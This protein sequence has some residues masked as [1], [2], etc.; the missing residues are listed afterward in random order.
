MT[1]SVYLGLTMTGGLSSK[2]KLASGSLTTELNGHDSMT[3][4][5]DLDSLRGIPSKYWAYRSGMLVATYTD[6][7]G[8]ERPVSACPISGPPTENREEGTVTLDGQGVT[9]IFEDR[10][11]LDKDY[12]VPLT[13]D[14]RKATVRFRSD[15]FRSIIGELFR[16]GMAKPNG[17]VPLV[18]P[19]REDGTRQRTYEGWNFANNGVWKR[20]KEITEVI[21][22]PD[23]IAR[24]EWADADHMAI[25]WRVIVGTEAQPELPQSK[26]TIWDGTARDSGIQSVSLSHDAEDVVHR[27]YYTGAGEGKA[28]ALAVD[29]LGRLPQDVPLVEGVYSDSD[30]EQT[31]TSGSSSLLAS[32]AR[33]ALNTAVTTEFNVT[34][35]ADPESDPIGTWWCGELTKLYLDGWLT[36]PDGE[37]LVRIL[38][39]KYDFSSD[40]VSFTCQADQ[41]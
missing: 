31:E 20:I 5:C 35:R 26:I 24:P 16:L 18:L 3:V 2:L 23:L 7:F 13:E 9:W 36:V 25:R 11:V 40:M 33:A 38:T 10:V 17:Y 4:T 12:A 39:A 6:A 41:E 28:I 21:N 8:V 29:Q 37:Y 14:P 15:T 30:A 1:W 19:A 32:K 22:G 34:A 27:S